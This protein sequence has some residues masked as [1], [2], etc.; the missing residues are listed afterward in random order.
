MERP[1]II[2]F[3]FN[4]FAIARV[5][6]PRSYRLVRSRRRA[7]PEENVAIAEA[8]RLL[9]DQSDSPFDGAEHCPSGAEDNWIHH[10]LILV[11]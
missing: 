6:R 10:E 2:A 8:A 11:D 3:A 1:A 7:V 4:E 9:Q 5:A